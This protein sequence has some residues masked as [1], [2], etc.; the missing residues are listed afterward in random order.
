M[1]DKINVTYIGHS[2]FLV[3]IDDIYM[4]FDYYV[5]DIPQIPK[6]SRVYVFVSH[7]HEDH[8][9]PEIFKLYPHYNIKYIFSY[10]I[11]L[12]PYGIR[13]Y[14]IP[15]EVIEDIVSIRYDEEYSDEY[16]R[17]NAFKSTDIGVAYLIECGG[18]NIYHA[19]D[20]NWWHWSG[21]SKQ[22]NNNMAANYK[23]GI[24]KL[25]EKLD[26]R[27]K[28][29]VLAMIPLD[30]R[31]EDSYYYGMKYFLENVECDNVF[32][33]HFAG[34]FDCISRFIAEHG[35]ENRIKKIEYRG[36]SFEVE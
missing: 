18:R 3:K 6:G 22:Y 10:D 25:T 9:N 36:Q 30:S 33:M 35:Y 32:P 5:G 14:S 19:G 8:F 12:T 11:K 4:I 16:I 23:A 15:K 21:E 28:K 26:E 31:L 34:D 1:K 24:K 17:V 13:K 7:R 29:L 20:H 27:N 2:G